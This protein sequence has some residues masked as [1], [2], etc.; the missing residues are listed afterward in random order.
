M[1]M[2]LIYTR[3]DEEMFESFKDLIKRKFA[4]INLGKMRYFLGVEVK[5]CETR[6]FLH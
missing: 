5:Q 1:L 6:T 4:M 2:I 3:N